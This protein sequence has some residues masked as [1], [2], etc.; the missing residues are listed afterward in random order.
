VRLRLTR[1]DRPPEDPG[2]DASTTAC[3]HD[4]PDL[5]ALAWRERRLDTVTVPRE[6]RESAARI[7]TLLRRPMAPDGE[8]CEVTVL[9]VEVATAKPPVPDDS[10]PI[11]PTALVAAAAAPLAFRF[12]RRRKAAAQPA[13]VTTEAPALAPPRVIV[14]IPR[15]SAA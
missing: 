15:G 1:S 9:P 6:A 13:A 14:D 10:L 11:G 12:W 7:D 2:A 5:N 8:R 4:G 3:A